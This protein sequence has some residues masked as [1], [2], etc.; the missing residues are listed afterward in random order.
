MIDVFM[1]PQSE[2]DFFDEGMS[3]EDEAVVTHDDQGKDEEA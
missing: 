3:P 1:T 2:D